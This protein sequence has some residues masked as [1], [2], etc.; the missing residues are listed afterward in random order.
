MSFI[1]ASVV[2]ICDQICENPPCSEICYSE[3]EAQIVD[4]QKNVEKLILTPEASTIIAL[5]S[6]KIRKP[7]SVSKRNGNRYK[8]GAFLFKN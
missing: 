3:I 8:K 6:S 4:K 2:K 7:G 1:P 5:P